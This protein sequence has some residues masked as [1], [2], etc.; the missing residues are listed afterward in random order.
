[1]RLQNAFSFVRFIICAY[2]HLFEQSFV[3][4]MGTTA[5]LQPTFVTLC[6]SHRWRSRQIFG[7]AKDFCPNFPKLVR[8]TFGPLFV[9]M[10][11]HEDCCWDDLKKKSSCNFWRHFY[12]YF[13]WVCDGFHSLC[14]DVRRFSPDFQGFCPNFHH[15]KILGMHVHLPALPPPTPLVEVGI[16]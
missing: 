15:I 14:L 11:S 8:K 6:R 9:Q 7:G 5:T 3:S 12:P 4:S 16:S 13:H 2:F 10:F 1:M